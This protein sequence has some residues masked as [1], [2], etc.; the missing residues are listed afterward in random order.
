MFKLSK[1]L[2]SGRYSDLTLTCDGQKFN[3]HKAIVCSQSPV[4]A[5]A[6][7]GNFQ[8]SI[9]NTIHVK[10]KSET[11]NQM[12]EFLYNQDYTADKSHATTHAA[13][14]LLQH[15]R[16]N[17]IAD[18]YR[19]TPLCHLA[20]LKLRAA[21][22]SKWSTETFSA[23]VQEAVGITG[24]LSLQD[25]LASTAAGHIEELLSSETF[26]NLETLHGLPIS[27]LQAVLASHQGR[28]ET[29]GNEIRELS[30]EIGAKEH[31]IK[32]LRARQDSETARANRVIQ[33]INHCISTLNRTQFCERCHGDVGCYI[34]RTG[35][36]SDKALNIWIVKE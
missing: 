35:T 18:Y 1:I 10:F 32:T 13:N 17:A 6:C 2:S 36:G 26:I 28:L 25:M 11:V 12:V 19:I 15:V 27:I 23:V 14:V 5:A 8:E 20:T 33:N 31:L 7:N 9:T 22:Q 21:F 34:T 24:D 30:L 16:V 29:L 4:L 3:V